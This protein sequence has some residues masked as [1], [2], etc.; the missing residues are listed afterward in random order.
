MKGYLIISLV[1]V[2]LS[3]S[4]FDGRPPVPIIDVP[5]D[6][7]KTE[8]KDLEALAVQFYNAMC[9]QNGRQDGCYKWVDLHQVQDKNW[10]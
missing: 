10:P 7:K 3:Q 5:N 2:C 6:F 9:R 4:I 1:I 8:V